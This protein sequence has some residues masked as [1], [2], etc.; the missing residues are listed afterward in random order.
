MD[1]EPHLVSAQAPQND[2]APVPQHIYV[3]KSLSYFK[4]IVSRDF[5]RLLVS[6][7]KARVYL[8]LK[9]RFRVKFFDFRVLA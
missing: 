5:E 8:L 1:P 7:H 4:G 2:A 9:F 3:T 6:T